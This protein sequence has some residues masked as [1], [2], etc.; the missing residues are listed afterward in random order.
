MH[1]SLANIRHRLIGLAIAKLKE[2]QGYADGGV[3]NVQPGK[4][5]NMGIYAVLRHKFYA[6]QNTGV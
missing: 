2:M 6:G 1:T 3:H 5:V 4:H